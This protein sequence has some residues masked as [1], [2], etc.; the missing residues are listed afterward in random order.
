MNQKRLLPIATLILSIQFSTGCQALKPRQ[1]EV[2]SQQVAPELLAINDVPIEVGREYPLLDGVG[3]VLGIPGKIL[4]WDRRVDNHSISDDTLSVMEDYLA[5]SNLQHVKVRANQYAPL[6]DWQRLRANKTVAWPWRY[7]LGTLSVAGEAIVPGRLFGGDHFN[8]FT[9]TIHLYSD[10]PAIAVHEGG[11]A[12]DFT[13]RKYQGTYAAAYLLVPMWH[14]TLAS[15]DAFAY[16][17][18]RGEI[19]RMMEANRILYPAYGTYLGNAIGSFVPDYSS[20]L[21]L[22]C[23]VAGHVNGR[24]LNRKLERSSGQ[25]LHNH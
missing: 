2:R 18:A 7:T 5:Q 12:K 19:N 1:I 15:E 9:Q 4:L 6:K 22:G 21:Y 25:Q 20:P 13:R 16:I 23:V 8:P 3:W 24:M 11:H 14:E 17:Q 10:I